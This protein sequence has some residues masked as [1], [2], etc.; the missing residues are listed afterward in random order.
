MIENI[1]S[2]FKGTLDYLEK[3]KE[4]HLNDEMTARGKVEELKELRERLLNTCSQCGEYVYP[5]YKDANIRLETHM[6]ERHPNTSTPM[7]DS[8]NRILSTPS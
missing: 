8:V 1:P 6:E 5:D 4:R 2:V 3:E 7:S